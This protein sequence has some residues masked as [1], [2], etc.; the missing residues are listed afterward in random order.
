MIADA[1]SGFDVW[2]GALRDAGFAFAPGPAVRAALADLGGL[3]DW[4]AFVASWEDLPLDGYMADCGR[5]RRRRHAVLAVDRGGAIAPQ[6]RQPHVQA[7]HY[8]PLHGGIERWFEPVTPAVLD[9]GTMRTVLG[10]AHGLF[11]ALSGP[12][13]G[14]RVEVHQFRIEAG[15]DAPG[16]P[17]PE[18]VHRDGVDW[19]LVLMVRRHNIAAGTTTIHGPDRR[20]IGAFTLS[21]PFDAALVDDHRCLHGVTPVVPV[22][23]ALP[24]FRDV[25]VATFVVVAD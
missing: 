17:T 15:V 13:P 7:L 24:A 10:A 6:P 4:P 14:W 9:G 16:R 20:E 5:Y 3:D 12:V 25:L 18:G 23:P 1:A 21:E 8:N 19:V 11:T 2:R 22:D